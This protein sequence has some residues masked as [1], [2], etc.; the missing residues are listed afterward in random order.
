MQ[1][2]EEKRSFEE[3]IAGYPLIMNGALF[4]ITLVILQNLLSAGRLDTPQ[5]VSLICFVIAIPLL[6]GFAVIDYMALS[7]KV[8]PFTGNRDAAIII[9]YVGILFDL[10]GITAAI[11]NMS[12]EVAV[13][14]ILVCIL[15]FLITA[16]IYDRITKL[17]FMI[18]TGSSK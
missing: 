11:W 18:Y 1:S 13:G 5:F 2:S 16:R 14:F 6:A 3:K 10:A 4:A 17:Y 9:E 8:D 15:T 12:W 7:A